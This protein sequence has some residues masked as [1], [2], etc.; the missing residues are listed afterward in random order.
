MKYLIIILFLLS[1]QVINASDSTNF[2]VIKRWKQKDGKIGY[3]LKNMETKKRYITICGC[4]TKRT[5]GEIVKIA[6]KDII[7]IDA[8]KKRKL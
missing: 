6:N 2:K 3:Q 7:L 1:P 8:P 4:E 5:K